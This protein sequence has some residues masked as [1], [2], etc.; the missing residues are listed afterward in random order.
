MRQ[1]NAYVKLEAQPSGDGSASD[2]G[3]LPHPHLAG[4]PHAVPD[5]HELHVVD[6]ISCE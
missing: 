4:R 1:T 6:S 5:G 2:G 3:A